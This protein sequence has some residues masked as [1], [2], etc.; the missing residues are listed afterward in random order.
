MQL[1]FSRRN[2]TRHSHHQS[3]RPAG[4]PRRLAFD[5]LE[6]R[7][8][9]TAGTLNTSPA[10]TF[11]VASYPPGNTAPGNTLDPPAVAWTSNHAVAMDSK[12][13]TVVVWDDSPTNPTTNQPTGQWTN[14]FQFYTEG[15]NPTTGATQLDAGAGGPLTYKSNPSQEVTTNV[16]SPWVAMAPTSGEFVVVWQS[17]STN[18]YGFNVASTYAQLYSD[19]QGPLT[20][21]ILVGAAGQA[22][23]WGVAMS[24]NGFDV[25]YGAPPAKYRDAAGPDYQILT[26]A[27][28]SSTGAPEGKPTSVVDDTDL[29]YSAAISADPA[30]NFVVGWSNTTVPKHGSLYH[31][32]DWQRYTSTGAASGSAVQEVTQDFPWSVNLATDSSDNAVLEWY[33]G[34]SNVPAGLYTQTIYA[35]D[36]L[37]SQHLVDAAAGGG[38]T[39]VAMQPATGAYVLSWTDSTG[40]QNGSSSVY[41]AT[42]SLDGTVET[43]PFVV[44]AAPNVLVNGHYDSLSHTPSAAI[45]PAGNVL[46]VNAGYFADGKSTVYTDGGEF[47]QFYLDPPATSA[48]PTT[49]SP[50]TSSPTGAILPSGSSTAAT[51]AAFAAYAYPGDD[52][53]LG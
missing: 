14:N 26:V 4:K 23:P 5:S 34:G 20:D 7:R 11:A 44:Y 38:R 1:G 12:G 19:T 35:N 8:L 24:D 9:L 53:T 30:G 2:A 49:T 22:L 17:E 47:G 25:L 29:S 50:V 6:D 41:A 10:Q 37:G 32:L 45:D 21:P 43:S 39:A 3:R 15:T 52:D 33:D 28:Y 31:S 27:R 48:A 18:S 46:T 13:D 16:G 51:D 36:T 40:G 42:Y